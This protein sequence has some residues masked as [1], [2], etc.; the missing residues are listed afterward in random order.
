MVVIGDGIELDACFLEFVVCIPQLPELRPARGSPHGG[1]VEDNRRFGAD[2][3]LVKFDN[4]S[5]CVG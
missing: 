4:V 1:A 5:L 3:I 2:P